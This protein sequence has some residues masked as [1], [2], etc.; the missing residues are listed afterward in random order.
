M[1][2]SCTPNVTTTA[3]LASYEIPALFFGNK[4]KNRIIRRKF[5]NILTKTKKGKK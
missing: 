5:V 2:D 1:S 3:N 4:K